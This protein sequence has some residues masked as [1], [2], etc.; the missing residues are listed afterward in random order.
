VHIFADHEIGEAGETNIE[1]ENTEA[2]N[3]DTFVSN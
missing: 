1:E 3:D 2:I